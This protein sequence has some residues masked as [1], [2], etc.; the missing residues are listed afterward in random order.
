MTRAELRAKFRVEN[1]DIPER[2][3]SDSTLNSW[4][5]TANLE[6]ATETRCIVTSESETFVSL[7]NTQTYDLEAN[8]ERF[9]DID[10]MPG[11]GVYFNGAPL[12]K[13]SPG[14]MNRVSRLWKTQN[15]GIPKRYWRRGAILWFDKPCETAGLEIAVDCILTP[16][17]FDNDSEE[18]FEGLSHL[19][20]YVDGIN[21]Y[22]QW[23][24]KPVVGKPQDAAQ[25]Y[26]DYVAYVAWM[27]K[28]VGGAKFGPIA[29]EPK[30]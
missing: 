28:R 5:T 8:I 4:M 12:E 15:S 6:I 27:K 17:P 11:G 30:V 25:A 3:I 18:P 9:H 24:S 20:A 14:A 29:I 26:K 13:S 19:Q 10:D 2:V 16:E 22:L 7:L 23:R 1:P 21:K